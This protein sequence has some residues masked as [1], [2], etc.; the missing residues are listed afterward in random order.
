MPCTGAARSRFLIM[1]NPSSP[2]R[3]GRRSS[4]KK[5]ATM[6]LKFNTEYVA[7]IVGGAG[8]LLF[9]LALSADSGMISANG[10]TGAGTKFAGLA[11]ILAGGGMKW[12][13]QG[14]SKQ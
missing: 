6:W 12:R 3:D 2:P 10:L 14:R 11:M 7:G 5:N 4:K 13:A 8:L 9:L 1:E